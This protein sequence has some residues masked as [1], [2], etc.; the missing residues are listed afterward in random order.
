[1][2]LSAGLTKFAD[3]TPEEFKTTMLQKPQDAP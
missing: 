3:M 2:G 1:M